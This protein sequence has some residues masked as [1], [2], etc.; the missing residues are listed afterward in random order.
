MTKRKRRLWRYPDDFRAAA[1]QRVKD[2]ESAL[3]VARDLDIDKRQIYRWMAK[4]KQRSERNS[5]V[6][7]MTAPGQTSVPTLAASEKSSLDLLRDETR[8]LKHALAKT[9]Q[10]LAD[11]TLEVDFFRGAL[12]QIEARRRSRTAIGETASTPKSAK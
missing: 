1:I 12:Q 10:A 3:A 11:K 5:G 7:P 4:A 8:R 2:G 9:K 6:N